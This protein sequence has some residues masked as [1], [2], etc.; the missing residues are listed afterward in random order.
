MASFETNR[1]KLAEL[2]IRFGVNLQ[3]DQELFISAPIAA[4]EFVR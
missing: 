4:V 2:A 3:Q 1:A